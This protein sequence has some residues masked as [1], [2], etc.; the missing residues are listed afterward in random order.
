MVW[1]IW[2][3]KIGPRKFGRKIRPKKTKS[4]KSKCL[5]KRRCK[6]KFAKFWW[7]LGGHKG[8]KISKIGKWE[9]YLTRLNNFWIFKIW[10]QISQKSVPQKFLR[11]RARST[12]STVENTNLSRKPEPEIVFAAILAKN[13]KSR[14]FYVQNFRC[15]WL[16]KVD[17]LVGSLLYGPEHLCQISRS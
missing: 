6:T 2:P 12:K 14:F 3:V 9:K 7:V 8:H 4:E 10:A 5:K 15:Y 13:R 17:I 16:R 1:K 11:F